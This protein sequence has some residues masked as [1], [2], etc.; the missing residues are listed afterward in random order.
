[1]IHKRKIP[2][3]ILQ[4]DLNTFFKINF[5]YCFYL[6]KHTEQT[7]TIE[8]EQQPAPTPHPLEKNKNRN[9]TLPSHSPLVLVMRRSLGL[10][11]VL[12]RFSIGV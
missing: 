8:Q 7:N 3:A 1:M 9:H 10:I 5:L 12:L 11:L 6:L 2:L 4:K